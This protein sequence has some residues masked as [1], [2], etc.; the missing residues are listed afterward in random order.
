MNG[1][2]I[3]LLLIF[4]SVCFNARGQNLA[5]AP[6]YAP[7]TDVSIAEAVK[8]FN[9]RAQENAVGKTQP[10]LTP[11]EV[12]AAIRGWIPG[13]HPGCEI[14]LP[15]FN[16]IAETEIIPAGSFLDFIPGW[17]G[18]KGYDYKVWWID[19]FVPGT[20]EQKIAHH[21]G[22]NF[23]LRAQMISSRPHQQTPELLREQQLMQKILLN[24]DPGK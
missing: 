4:G 10:P 12:L 2:R 19:L 14:F 13:E 16:K 8:Q 6:Y 11:D 15:R 22:Y 9:V 23:R 17:V 3:L 18:Y 1:T 7:K 20:D 24:Q 5:D 21:W